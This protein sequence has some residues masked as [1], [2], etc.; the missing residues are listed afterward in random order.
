VYGRREAVIIF[1]KIILKTLNIL[2][3]ENTLNDLHFPRLTAI[4]ILDYNVMRNGEKI[5]KL[6]VT[7]VNQDNVT[8]FLAEGK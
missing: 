8:N 3:F 1:E 4:S 6:F 2:K 5:E 7:D